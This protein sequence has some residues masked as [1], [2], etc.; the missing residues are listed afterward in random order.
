ML[1]S[2]FVDDGSVAEDDA[3]VHRAE[4]GV[5]VA[6]D[7]FAAFELEAFAEFTDTFDFFE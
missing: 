5:G 7:H 1:F 3:V 4:L 6:V 2:L